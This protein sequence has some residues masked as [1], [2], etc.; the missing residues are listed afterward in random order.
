MNLLTLINWSVIGSIVSIFII[1]R[2]IVKIFDVDMMIIARLSMIAGVALLVSITVDLL[3]NWE[4]LQWWELVG[5]IIFLF[6]IFVF[7]IFAIKDL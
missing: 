7:E 4:L 1:A 3:I 6:V 2:I 5:N